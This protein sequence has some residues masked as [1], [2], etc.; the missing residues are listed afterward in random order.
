MSISFPNLGFSVII[1][2]NKFFKSFFSVFFSWTSIICIWV[3]GWTRSPLSFIHSLCSLIG[4]FKWTVFEFVE[5]FFLCFNLLLNLFM[6]F[7]SSVTLFFRFMISVWYF[8][9]VFNLCWNFHFVHILFSCASWAFLWCL[10]WIFCQVFHVSLFHCNRFSGVLL[11][12][13]V[14]IVSPSYFI[15]LDS[16]LVYTY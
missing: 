12:S 10:F 11:Y 2:L 14:W 6:E 15:F 13:F 7:F 8:L 4:Y 3:S 5:Y 1:S 16:V 9:T